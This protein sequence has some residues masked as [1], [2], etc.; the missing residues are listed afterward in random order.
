MIDIEK[1]KGIDEKSKAI[2]PFGRPIDKGVR[3]LVVLL[4]YNDFITTQ[5]CWGHKN[6][7]EPFPW[8]DIEEK[9]LKE[10]ESL[11][12]DLEIDGEYIEDTIRI[13]PKCE[14]LI[15]GRKEFN[16][17]KTKLKRMSNE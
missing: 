17:L 9:Y 6:H 12:S 8:V 4:N 2:P 5:S 10:I 15:E 7:G 16:K 14:D 11:I 1:Y 3:E 13:Y